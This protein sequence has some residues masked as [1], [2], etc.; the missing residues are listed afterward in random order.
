MSDRSFLALFKRATKRAIALLL[1]QKE[2]QK[3]WSLFRSFK[4][5]DEKSDRSFALSNRAKDQKWAKKRAIAHFQNERMPNPDVLLLFFVI[6]IIF[7][8]A[9]HVHVLLLLF[10]YCHNTSLWCR[11]CPSRR[12]RST[13]YLPFWWLLSNSFLL[14]VVTISI[15]LFVLNFTC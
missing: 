7:H 10:C 9:V 14:V 1:F 6:I 13:F 12:C 2:Q 11:C 15:L 8:W 5:S 3:E 4:K